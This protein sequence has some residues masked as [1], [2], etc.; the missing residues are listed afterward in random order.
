MLESSR[1]AFIRAPFEVKIEEVPIP[2]LQNDGDVL[3]RVQAVGICGTD[4]LYA[5]S[6]AHE[7]TRFGHETAATVIDYGAG[8]T[9]LTAG[10]LLT[11]QA[12]TPCGVCE[13]CMHGDVRDCQDWVPSRLSMAFAD[14]MVV[15]RRALW[16]VKDLSPVEATLIEPLSVALDLVDVAD[17]KLGHSVAIIGPGPIGLMAVKISKLYGALKVIVLGTDRDRSRFPIARDLGAD[18]TID[19]TQ[20]SQDPI[21]VVKAATEGLGVD[22]VLVTAPARVISQALGMVR[23]GGIISYIGFEVEDENALISINLNDFHKRRLQLRASY[24]APAT[25]YPLAAKLLATRQIDPAALIT[26]KFAL[27]DLGQAL[28]VAADQADSAI[29]VVCMVNS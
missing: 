29:K 28:H 4:I 2:T 3:V 22:R 1:V 20:G 11:V 18:I 9:D 15:P 14:H 23:W 17:I 8:V 5:R 21:A 19:V 7:W 13:A 26:H 27:E 10:D 24:A 16:R 6:W 25:R 12:T